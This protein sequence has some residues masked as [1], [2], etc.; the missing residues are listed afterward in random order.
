MITHEEAYK[1][2]LEVLPKTV[3]SQSGWRKLNTSKIVQEYI[4]QQQAKD[5]RAKK[6]EKLLGLYQK[7]IGNISPFN[8][9]CEQIRQLEEALK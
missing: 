4:T 9:Y 2:L 7:A 5:E 6:V 1:K 3:G 8:P